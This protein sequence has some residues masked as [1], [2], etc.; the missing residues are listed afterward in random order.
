[1]IVMF[2]D[3]FFIREWFGGMNGLVICRVVVWLYFLL[4]FCFVWILIVIVIDWYFGVVWFLWFFLILCY[5]WFVIMGLWIWIIGLV[6][7]MEVMVYL[8][9]I[10][11]Y[12]F[13]VIDYLYVKMNVGNIIVLCL[14]FFNFFVFFLVMIV[15]YLIV[16]YCLWLCDLLGEGI[17]YD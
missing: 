17:N 9:F 5:I 15:L 3:F 14:L 4:L 6:I 16:C 10:G 13:C 2:S 1:M 7:G 8:V 12:V 11:R